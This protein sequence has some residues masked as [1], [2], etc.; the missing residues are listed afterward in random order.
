M[1]QKFSQYLSSSRYGA[2]AQFILFGFNQS[3][4]FGFPSNRPTPDFP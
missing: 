1:H 3:A 4:V 2:S